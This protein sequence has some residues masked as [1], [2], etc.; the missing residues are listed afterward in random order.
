MAKVVAEAVMHLGKVRHQT[1]A[2]GLYWRVDQLS[3]MNQDHMM[4]G[5]GIH[6]Q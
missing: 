3:R 5:D 1:E 2:R 6:V 4:D